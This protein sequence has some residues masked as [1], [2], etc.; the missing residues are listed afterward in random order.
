MLLSFALCASLAVWSPPV[1]VADAPHIYIID[2]F[3]TAAECRAVYEEAAPKL[4]SSVVFDPYGHK[5]K[6]AADTHLARQHGVPRKELSGMRATIAERMDL[7]AMQPSAN[8]DALVV[9]EYDVE[10]MYQLHTDSNMDIGRVATALLFLQPA[11]EGGQLVF[12]WAHAVNG[13][14]GSPVGV[15]GRGLHPHSIS[16]HEPLPTLFAGRDLCNAASDTLTIEPRTGRLV[17]FFNHDG[18]S[19]QLKPRSLHGSCPIVRGTKRIAQQFYSWHAVGESNEMSKIMK[20]AGLA[21]GWNAIPFESEGNPA[22]PPSH[23][24]PV[25]PQT[26][27]ARSFQHWSN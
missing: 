13:T 24:Q 6:Q 7:A 2:D 19:R 14:E 26:P 10:G 20:R 5:W 18:Q 11:E 4:K 25:D 23:S 9:K 16:P 17:I 27:G 22:F 3:A 1:L 12:P 21:D 15:S 8:S